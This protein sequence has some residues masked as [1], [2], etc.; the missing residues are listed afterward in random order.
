MSRKF[1][2][3]QVKLKFAFLKACITQVSKVFP[4]LLNS[5]GTNKPDLLNPDEAKQYLNQNWNFKS[6]RN[7]RSW[8]V[9]HSLVITAMIA[10]T[11]ALSYLF[12]YSEIF[13]PLFSNKINHLVSQKKRFPNLVQSSA[14]FSILN[15]NSP[16]N[17]LLYNKNK[18]IS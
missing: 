10:C 12:T 2:C 3:F 8:L 4:G 1:R 14:L 7:S 9:R 5:D 18:L 6:K 15:P 13:F 16:L 11:N 17:V